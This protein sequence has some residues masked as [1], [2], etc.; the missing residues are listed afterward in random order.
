M[1]QT[2]VTF[3]GTEPV[4]PGPGRDTASFL[5]NGKYLVDTG[6][7]AVLRMKSFGFNPMDLET[8][9]ITHCHHDH[10]LGL[11]QIL[12]YLRMRRRERPDR[13]PL[14]II[15]PA[16]D[17]ARVVAL[18]QRFL[19]T[20][21]FPDL[22][23]SPEILP[24]NPGDSYRTAAFHL[25][26]CASVHPVQALTYRFTD[27]ATGAQIAWTGDTAYAPHIADHVRGVD[28]LITEASHGPAS[29]DPTSNPSLHSGAPD[30]A[31][32]A[33][34][35]GVGR[36]ALIHCPA[37]QA[38]AALVAA[39]QIFPEAFFPGEGETVEVNGRF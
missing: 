36:L 3:L 33:L 24:L 35:A 15:G 2:T 16:E 11:P 7:Y 14:Q 31:R 21:R 10:Y 37:E 29:P 12:F 39:R 1:A 17:I 30:A 34:A 6:W 4:V 20:E 9:M 32:L 8:L 19:Q 25:T 38:E 27:Q 18:A 26:T 23:Y 13:P 28:L 22:E 5:I